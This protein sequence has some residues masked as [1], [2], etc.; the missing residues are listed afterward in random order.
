MSNSNY[1]TYTT[2]LTKLKN[3]HLD[4]ESITISIQ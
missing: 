2:Q 3:T 1:Q 4:Y